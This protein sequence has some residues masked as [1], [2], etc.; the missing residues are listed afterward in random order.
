M[1]ADHMFCREA[2]NLPGST[3]VPQQQSTAST[4]TTTT[5]TTSQQEIG[6][7][8]VILAEP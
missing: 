8:T 3:I 5:T 6:G 1:R 7:F 2:N 4:T